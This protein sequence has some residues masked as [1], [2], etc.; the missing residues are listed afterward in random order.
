[1]LRYPLMAAAAL[2]FLA[3]PAG[4]TLQISA[5]VGGISVQ[6]ADQDLSCD[7]N[8]APGQL[9]IG[10]QSIAGV[11][12]LGSSQTQT[13]GTLG[14]QPNSLNSSSFQIINNSGAAIPITLAVAGTDFASPTAAYSASGSGTFQSAIGSTIHLGFFGD[15]GNDQGADNPNDTPGVQ[16]ATFDHNATLATDAF[17]TNQPGV[18]ETSGPFS[19]TLFASGTIID[20]G[21]LVGRTQAIISDV[22]AAP[23]TE[24]APLGMML[25]GL[26]GLYYARRRH[27]V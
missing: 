24:P 3:T 27:W 18:L 21:T 20:G 23:V 6:C 15:T 4:A 10:D 26:T 2:A 17:S 14:G 12:F 22:V 9:A 19:M 1:M 8:P 13:I 16:L 7:T 25:V 5:L 11:Q